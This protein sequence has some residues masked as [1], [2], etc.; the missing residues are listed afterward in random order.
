MNVY[1]YTMIKQA[2]QRIIPGLASGGVCSSVPPHL[3]TV[4]SSLCFSTAEPKSAIFADT[5]AGSPA[6]KSS[7]LPHFM[8]R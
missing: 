4:C 1:R 8:S 3:G 2:C 6:L 5:L 7:T